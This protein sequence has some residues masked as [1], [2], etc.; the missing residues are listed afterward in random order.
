MELKIL[1]T[2]DRA[3]S[4]VIGVILMVAITVILA[5]VIGTFVLGLGQNVQ[6]TPSASFDFEFNINNT[7]VDI[8]HS[9]GDRLE[10]GDNTG[11]L[12][13]SNGSTRA[14]WV[15]P[16]AGNGQV[17]NNVT[18]GNEYSDF[19]YEEGETIRVVWQ[20]TNNQSSATLG[21]QESPS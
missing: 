15:S 3:V 5:A 1:L 11:Y 20:G 9:G 2:E 19:A 8:T 18:A 6:S 7:T 12:A 14:D 21:Q 13:V 17:V 4:P 10:L 16:A